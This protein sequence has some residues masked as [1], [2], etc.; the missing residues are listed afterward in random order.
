MTHMYSLQQSARMSDALL[1]FY[2]LAALATTVYACWHLVLQMSERGLIMPAWEVRAFAVAVIMGAA[3]VGVVELC[4]LAHS[5]SAFGLGTAW[6][7]VAALIHYCRPRLPASPDATP[8]PVAATKELPSFEAR[9]LFLMGGLLVTVLFLLAILTPPTSWDSFTYHIPRVLNWL[10]NGSVAHFATHD[11][12]QVESG[13]FSAYAIMQLYLVTGSDRLVNLVQF[14][15]MIL[16]VAG[17]TWLT[18]QLL[19]FAQSRRS[20]E[21]LPPSSRARCWAGLFA[22]TMPVGIV[23]SITTQTDYVVALWVV[24]SVVFGVLF[25]AHRA[26]PTYATLFGASLALGTLTKA[27]MVI[28]AGLLAAFWLLLGLRAAASNATRTRALVI[29]VVVGILIV[30]PHFVR[31]MRIFGSPL[32]SDYIYALMRNQEQRPRVWVSNFVRNLSLHAA[33]GIPPLTAGVNQLLKSAH[34]LSGRS[35]NERSSTFFTSTFNYI[36]GYPVSDNSAGN[37]W[38]LAIAL[39]SCCVVSIRSRALRKPALLIALLVL[40]TFVIQSAYLVWSE[41]NARFHLP[42]FLMI[43]PLVGIALA[44]FQPLLRGACGLVLLI[45]AFHAALYNRSRPVL[46]G[47]DFLFQERE[48]QYFIETP[49]LYGPCLNAVTDVIAS[50]STNV[51][52]RMYKDYFRYLD[53]MEYPFWVMLR[54]RGFKGRIYNIGITNQT[55]RLSNSVP[56]Q[57]LISS[58]R[59]PAGEVSHLLPHKLRYPPIDVYFSETQSG[60]IRVAQVAPSGEELALAANPSLLE[61]VDNSG[62]I[63]FT[64]A[65]QGVLELNLAIVEN[66][67]LMPGPTTLLARS[68]AGFAQA[69]QSTN[70]RH[71]LEIPL[72][73][74]QTAL[75]VAVPPPIKAGFGIAAQWVWR[76][77]DEPLPYVYIARVYAPSNHPS[78]STNALTLY[79]GD[80]RNVQVVSGM[81]GEA[82][83]S[84]FSEAATSGEFKIGND[85]FSTACRFT[86]GVAVAAVPLGR[87]TNQFTASNVSGSVIRLDRVDAGFRREAL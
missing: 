27:T 78:A 42:L 21:A 85:A 36:Q 73:P 40:M 53:E 20:S 55:A 5:A 13:P 2:L 32:G 47:S 74:G 38:H 16:S 30:G 23:Q 3:L 15:A 17:V 24:S 61:L 6:F 80:L 75:Q 57:S 87:G 43:A 37:F 22:L 45:V 8:A 54:N 39:L 9:L 41:W 86:N 12:R 56:I 49:N 70:S 14:G 77:T 34:G 58:L 65:R 11:T 28:A 44:Q 79:P 29:L 69:S 67:V 82:R 35:D 10:Q 31:N 50:E 64:T 83:L 60:W 72:P 19:T 46:G 4:S 84:F 76:P 63:T 7:L 52:L 71:A 51:G 68:F 18:N 62:T 1:G 66:S 26:S 59:G 25:A 48:R 81:K 33:S